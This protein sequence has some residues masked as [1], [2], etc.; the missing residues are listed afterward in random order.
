MTS[1]WDDIRPTPE[2]LGF[3]GITS[4][5][6]DIESVLIDERKVPERLRSLIGYA[7]H[8]AI[9]DDI[10]RGDLMW[11][12]PREEL[13]AFVDSVWPLRDEI[14]SWCRAQRDHVPVPDEVVLFD[15]MLEAA[16]E[17]VACHIQVDENAGGSGSPEI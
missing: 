12:T 11:L 8:W 17:A 14:E 4:R 10:E 1:E 7:K 9:G 6:A 5:Y 3:Q 2:D 15:Q 13:Q 16:A